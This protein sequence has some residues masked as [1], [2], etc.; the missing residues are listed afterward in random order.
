MTLESQF[1]KLMRVPTAP[2]AKRTRGLMARI[3]QHI[4]RFLDDRDPVICLCEEFFLKALPQ[5]K[6]VD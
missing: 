5:E 1:D 2:S 3:D 6:A 4:K